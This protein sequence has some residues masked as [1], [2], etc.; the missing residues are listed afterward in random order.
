[1]SLSLVFNFLSRISYVCAAIL[2]LPHDDAACTDDGVV[3]YLQG[4]EYNGRNPKEVAVS[5][6]HVSRQAHGRHD[7]VE[8]PDLVVMANGNIIVEYVEVTHTDIATEQAM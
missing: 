6:G 1:M 8:C 3:A 7:R 2:S 5:N 4:L